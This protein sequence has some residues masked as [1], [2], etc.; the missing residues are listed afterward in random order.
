MRVIPK[1]LGFAVGKWLGA[2]AAVLVLAGQAAVAQQ[3]SAGQ[4]GAE[5][6]QQPTNSEELG[7]SRNDGPRRDTP[8]LDN[9]GES[10]NEQEADMEN[11]EDDADQGMASDTTAQSTGPVGQAHQDQENPAGPRA[12]II[13]Q[14]AFP[15]VP[16][17]DL[18]DRTLT[19]LAGVEVGQ[20]ENVVVNPQT[21][22]AALLVSVG[23]FLGMGDKQVLVSAAEVE[24][25]EGEIIWQSNGGE[26]AL[27]A[28]PPYRQ[29]DFVSVR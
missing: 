23:G 7:V 20:V 24:A 9:W 22:E 25:G 10:R 19:N 8:S 1:T 3:N 2:G 21:G 18:Q 6:T 12:E 11:A 17:G 27:K 26:E 4:Q 13:A 29:Q 14:E 5:Q 15:N 16:L 28:L